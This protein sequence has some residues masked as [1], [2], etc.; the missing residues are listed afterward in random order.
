[1]K[2]ETDRVGVNGN[3]RA[4]TPSA[5]LALYRAFALAVAYVLM[6]PAGY[7]FSFESDTWTVVGIVTAFALYKI[8]QQTGVLKI[9]LPQKIDF[10]ID[11]ASCMALPFFTNGFYSPFLV[12]MFCP[13]L[14]A[15]LFFRMG[16]SFAV[17]VL[18][19]LATMG[20]HAWQYRSTL[21]Q[22]IAFGNI[23]QFI[24]IS[25]PVISLIV[26]YLPHLINVN[27]SSK[28]KAQ[29]IAEERGR[30]SRDMHDG[31]AQSLSIARWRC[32]M[33][34]D[35]LLKAHTRPETLGHLDFIVQTLEDAQR[36][37]RTVISELYHT[38][39]KQKGLIA[40]LAQQA[41]E[42]T[43]NFGTPCRLVVSDGQV[44]LSDMAEMQ[45]L[46]VAQEALNNVRKHAGAST[47]ELSLESG[48]GQTV[49]T[50]KDDGRGFDP[51]YTIYGHGLRVMEERA[52]SVGGQ[53]SV[54]SK[55]EQGTKI[56]VVLNGTGTEGE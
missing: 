46:C 7:Y 21:G 44:R 24:V 15:A 12:Y 39:V 3:N 56:K 2:T 37:A 31:L 49:L 38:S 35:S 54:E 42:Y 30:L 14:T 33:M 1:M 36:E 43:K 48:H 40:G 41:T 50:I 25:Y 47:I 19:V 26:A 13:V 23:S 55:P 28:V 10:G 52:E 20:S 4:R 53:I 17:A 6:Y 51:E 18:P 9:R 34:R 11:L 8:G 22:I 27:M 29:A 5:F 45:L 32:E 16:T